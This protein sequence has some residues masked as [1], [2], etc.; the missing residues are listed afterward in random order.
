MIQV[1]RFQVIGTPVV[2]YEAYEHYNEH[3]SYMHFN[4][5]KMGKVEMRKLPD[6]IANT[7][8]FGRSRAV[9]NFYDCCKDEAID[10]IMFAYPH[11]GDNFVQAGA[12]VFNSAQEAADSFISYPSQL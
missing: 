2:R 6:D 5:V 10:A 11:L 7:S 12:E 1:Y 9:R 8:W 4:G 3:S